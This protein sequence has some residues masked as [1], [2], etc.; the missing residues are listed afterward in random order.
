MSSSARICYTLPMQCI[1]FTKK[2]LIIHCIFL[3][4]SLLAAYIL[5]YRLGVAPL[6]NWDEA[7]YGDITKNMLA[8]NDYIIPHWNKAVLIDKA[9]FYMWSSVFFSK[10][11]GLSELSMRLTSALSGFVVILL[12]MWYTY[13]TYG[14]LPSLVAYSSITLNNLFIFR[15]RSGNLDS[16]TTLLIFISYFVMISK[17]K[18]R[19][20]FLGLLFAIIYLTRTSFVIFPLSIFVLHEILFKR[21]ELKQNVI[22]YLLLFLTFTIV[23]GG[24]ILLGYQR[25]GVPFINYYIFNSDQNTILGASLKFFK[26]DYFYYSYYSLQRRLFLFFVIGLILLLPKL[27]KPE[28][29]PQVLF[30]TALLILLTFSQRTDNWYLIPSLPF[31]SLIIAYAVYRLIEI[32]KLFKIISFL[33]CI[34]VLYTSYRTYTQNIIPILYT[35]S[36]EGEAAS[37]R[38]IDT[39]A[40]KND[41]IVRLDHLYPTLV[42]YSNRKVLASPVGS[43]TRSYFL[44]RED[45]LDSIKKKKIHWASGQKGVIDKFL[46]ENAGIKYES[47]KINHDEFVLKFL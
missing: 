44:S 32:F 5:F 26:L 33:L 34:A 19:L 38:Y 16:L 42:Y 6:D 37:G 22:H 10:I 1:S 40:D 13:T 25:E 7:W 28:Y 27:K 45:L 20:L 47:I 31:W 46:A 18:Y 4:L 11:I 15:S 43:T 21:K 35:I 2:S 12:V 30:A 9:P 41:I 29:L 8:T 36:A 24:W 39:H 14:L 17:H 23:A 3:S